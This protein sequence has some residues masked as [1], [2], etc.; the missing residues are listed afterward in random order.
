MLSKPLGVS[1]SQKLSSRRWHYFCNY[2]LQECT[3]YCQCPSNFPQVSQQ[4]EFMQCPGYLSQL[5]MWLQSQRKLFRAAH[6][7]C[8]GHI[9]TPFL[10]RGCRLHPSM[11]QCCP[12]SVSMFLTVKDMPQ[13][14]CSELDGRLIQRPI[15]ALSIIT[16][17]EG[18]CAAP[19]FA[20]LRLL[21]Y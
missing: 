14:H 13:V 20:D 16:K 5:Q 9:Q 19:I 1:D 17:R 4:V 2:W 7:L 15:R 11:R 21:E 12:E 3:M 18:R 10:G 6:L 8:F